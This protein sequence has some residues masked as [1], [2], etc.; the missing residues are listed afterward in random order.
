MTIFRTPQE[1]QAAAR[2]ARAEGKTI[3]FV[4]TMGALHDGHLTLMREA[5]TRVDILAVS[6][7]VNPTQ[8]GPNEDLT[9]YPRDFE[10]DE[11]KCA[12]AGVD[13]LFYPTPESMY[14]NGYRTYVTVEDWGNV[15]CGRSRPTHFRGVTTV[16][17]KLFH[18]VLPASAYFGWKDA[19]QFLIL[20]KM[21]KDLNLDVEM[22]GVETVREAD[23]L[24][25]SSRNVYLT[26]QERREA[27][28]LRRAL[29]AARQRALQG[30][31]DAPQAVQDI[32]DMIGRE[33]HGQIDYVECVSMTDLSPARRLEPGTLV[34]LAVRFGR[35]R[36]IDNIRIE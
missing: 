4:P 3:G 34:A 31:Y 30:P 10:G 13:W 35:A 21:V 16:V 7:F 8:F 29:L 18:I 19:Q 33:S 24:A 23:G 27:P 11:R 6:I 14:P 36:L 32:R 20:R 15:L 12:G 26:P 28:V 9:A 1:M 25:M 22:V 2:R 5:R 17:L